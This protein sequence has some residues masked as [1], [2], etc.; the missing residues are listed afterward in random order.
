MTTQPRLT[1]FPVRSVWTAACFTIA[2]AA[3]PSNTGYAQ[4]SSL[5]PPPA[6]AQQTPVELS[7][8]V[9][10]ISV[11]GYM[12]TN[13][14]SGTAMNA[15]L[16]E[17]P[18]TINVITSEFLSD[19]LVGE[20]AQ[21]FDYNSS[22]TQTNR[23]PVDN[24]SASWSIRGF[25]NRNTLIDGV[26]GGEY[27]PTHLIDR[28]EVV[29]GPNTLYGQ[30]DP[31][32]LINIVTKRP[33]G[34][35]RLHLRQRVGEQS[36][37]ETNLDYDVPTLANRFRL[38]LLGSYMETDGWRPV[39]GKETGVL[40]L[41]SEFTVTPA[42][43]LLLNISG[44]E[45]EG[46]PTQRA[47]FSFEQFPRDLN[48]DGDTLDIVAGEN[49]ASIRHNNTFLPRDYTSATAEAPFFQDNFYLHTGVRHRFSP[50]VQAQYMFVKSS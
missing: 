1:L 37:F 39:D 45:T 15:P 35:G 16:R 23:Q 4:A 38:R 44:S 20:L 36:L 24:R 11:E 21:V 42:T 31:G 34:S 7:P 32:G 14:I 41:M 49:E 29:K 50:Q 3:L 47:T 17:V 40:G 12:A 5:P 18:M 6:T 9:V 28:V 10:S 27:I 46:I 8:F 30:S 33:T 22:I 19:A 43:T 48:G 2:W 13:T 26:A 25:R